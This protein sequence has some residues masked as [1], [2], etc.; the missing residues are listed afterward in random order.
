QLSYLSS[1]IFYFLIKMDIPINEFKIESLPKD[2]N[3]FV[4][5]LLALLVCFI[6]ATIGFYIGI[7]FKGFIVPSLIFVI[8][9]FIIPI[10]GK[11]DPRNLIS[12]LGHKVF[13]FQGRMKL[14][15]PIDLPIPFVFL[16]LLTFMVFCSVIAYVISAKQNKYVV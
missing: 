9:D 2:H 4:Q 5:Y 8:Y 7:L 3:V 12:I 16:L 14:F 11:L 1:F 10:M 15:E 6:F 13:N